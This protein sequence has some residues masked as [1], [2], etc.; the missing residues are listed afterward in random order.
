MISPQEAFDIFNK[1]KPINQTDYMSEFEHVYLLSTSGSGDSDGDYITVNKQTGKVDEI[2]FL[3][4]MDLIR[5]LGDEDPPEYDIKN[6]KVTK[7]GS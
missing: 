4:Y 6:G 5:A 2:D 3:G 7:R 1:A